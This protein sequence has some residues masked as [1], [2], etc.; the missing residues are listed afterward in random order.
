M[1]SI[2]KFLGKTF[3]HKYNC[4]DFAAE[5]WE[6]LTGNAARYL[7]EDWSIE[8]RSRLQRITVPVS[9]CLIIMYQRRTIPH[10][11]I[12]RNGR[13]LHLTGMGVENQPIDVAARGFRNYR[14]Y[15]PK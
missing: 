13:V 12:Y 15:V 4:A 1:K 9:P 14:L 6:Y 5:V 10:V 8:S 7:V 3:N 11:G 2:D